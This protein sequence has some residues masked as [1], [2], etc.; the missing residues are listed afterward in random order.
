MELMGR[1]YVGFLLS[2]CQMVNENAGNLVD[3]FLLGCENTS[4]S[5]Y[6][7]VVSVDDDGI[8]KSKLPEGRAEFRDLL[9]A[10]GAGVVNVGD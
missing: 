8:D 3:V 7:A 9:L 4:M 10:V 6:D 5:G 1:H 2:R